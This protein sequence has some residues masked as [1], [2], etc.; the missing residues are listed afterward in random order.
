MLAPPP[1]FLHNSPPSRVLFGAGALAQL[2]A[3]LQRL[4]IRRPVVV[5]GRRTAASPLYRAAAAALEGLAVRTYLEMPEHSPIA[6]VRAVRELAREHGAD[7]FV[8]IGGGSASDACKAA[9][10]WLAEGGELADHASRFTPPATLVMPQLDRPKLPVVAV[11]CTA[12][13]A[14]VTPSAGVKTEDGRKLVMSDPKV[15]A[16]LVVID[17]EAAL[18]VPA[19]LLLATAMNGLAHCIEGLYSKV[20]TPITTAL[21]LHAI[22][23]FAQ[24]MPAVAAAPRAVGARGE[25]LMAAHLSGLVLL[26]ARTC[27]HHAVCHALGASAGV[28]HGDANSIVLPHAMEFNAASAEAAAAMADAARAMGAGRGT[29]ADAVACVRELQQAVGVPTR[30]RDVGVAREAL[31]AVAAKVMHERGLYFNPRA[32]ESPTAVERMLNEAW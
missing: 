3:E 25:L 11:P 10:I 18:D 8:A 17:P 2:G 23:L 31:P 20:R 16:R 14:E 27:F 22:G 24:A 12:S 32:V 15:A 28:S 19:P 1:T 30:L 6:A 7:G 9:A 29:A 5:S 21:A 26:N 4:G 13:A